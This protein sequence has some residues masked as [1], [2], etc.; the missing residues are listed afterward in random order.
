MAGENLGT[1]SFAADRS[2]VSP[3]SQVEMTS[4][5]Q[6]PLTDT[7]TVNGVHLVRELIYNTDGHGLNRP[8]TIICNKLAFCIKLQTLRQC[9][10]RH[11]KEQFQNLSSLANLVNIA[12]HN[13][14]VYSGFCCQ[15]S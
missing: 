12:E 4:I 7:Q 11:K 15:F 14:H 1:G 3:T 13:I 8:I 2:G 10:I 9:M 6:A 5:S